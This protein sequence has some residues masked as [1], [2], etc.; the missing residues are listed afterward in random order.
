M[1]SDMK[2]ILGFSI[3]TVFL[4][5]LTIYELNSIDV[6]SPV[7]QKTS[8]TA[9]TSPMATTSVTV[10]KEASLDNGKVTC[11]Y[12]E[13]EKLPNALNCIKNW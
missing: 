3:L 4:V 13:N 10:I 7:S 2:Y 6:K 1:N 9:A 5:F 8:P 12:T 11:Y